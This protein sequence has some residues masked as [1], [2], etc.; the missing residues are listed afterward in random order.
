MGGLA[1]FL[2]DFSEGEAGS[3]LLQLVDRE[4]TAVLI[5]F[6]GQTHVSVF[7]LDGV[8]VEEISA[9]GIALRHSPESGAWYAVIQ[10]LEPGEELEIIVTSVEG[11]ERLELT[12]EQ[13]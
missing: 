8:A 7:L 13:F 2:A 4:K 12:V 10:G 11:E 6:M 9:D 3:S 5:D 1:F